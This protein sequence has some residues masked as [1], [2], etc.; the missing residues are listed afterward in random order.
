MQKN[1]SQIFRENLNISEED[2]KEAQ[3]IKAEKGAISEKYLSQKK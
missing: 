3:R 2:L 1:L